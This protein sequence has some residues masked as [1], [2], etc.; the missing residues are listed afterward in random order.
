MNSQRPNWDQY[1]LDIARLVCTRSTCIRRSVGAV[2]VKDR[3]ILATGYNG[4]PSGLKHCDEA[5]CLRATLNIPSGDRLDI[6]RG[7]HAEQ[8][9]IIQCAVYG[10]STEGATIYVTN[11]PCAT[12]AKMLINAKIKEVVYAGDYSDKLGADLLA[13]ADITIRIIKDQTE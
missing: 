11:Q 4:V 1:F 12:C 10:V 5:G 3:R 9:A 8:N 13:E 2:L 6:C 7:L